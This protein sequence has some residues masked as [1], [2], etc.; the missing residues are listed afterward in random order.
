MLVLETALPIKFASTIEEALGFAP[1][2]PAA[3]AHLENLPQ[4]V[5]VMPAEVGLVKSFI[6]VHCT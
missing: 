3:F 1:P 5:E 2:V 4:R 6:E